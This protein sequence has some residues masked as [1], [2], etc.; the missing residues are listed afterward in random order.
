MSADKST[1]LYK[2]EVKEYNKI[3]KENVTKTYKKAPEKST[4][5]VDNEASK[6]VTKMKIAEKVQK[7]SSN[8]CFVTLKDHKDNFHA[9]PQCRL[10]NP[11]KSQV[12]KISKKI[13]ENFVANVKEESGLMLWKNDHDVIN[14]FKNL[15][16]GPKIKFIQFDIESFYPSISKELLTK[17]LEYAATMVPVEESD[18]EIIFHSRK[19]LL[20]SGS[21]CWMKKD[22]DFFDVTMGAYDGAE[23]C[24]LVGLYLLS[25]IKDI[26]V[27]ME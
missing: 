26:I 13:L 16:N 17:A 5:E 9:H 23:V 8:E 21:S 3:V 24:E 20:F 25:K 6:I 2:M 12:G 1:N 22:G 19:S 27:M 14:W 15:E 4:S 11:A 10:I 18:L 7:Y